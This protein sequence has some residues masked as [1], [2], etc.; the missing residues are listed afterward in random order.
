[1]PDALFIRR[2]SAAVVSPYREGVA[3][4]ARRFRLPGSAYKALHENFPEQGGSFWIESARHLA[5]PLRALADRIEAQRSR[6]VLETHLV[7][8]E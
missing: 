8:A 7:A 6:L 4:N 1:M 3:A 5:G 2:V